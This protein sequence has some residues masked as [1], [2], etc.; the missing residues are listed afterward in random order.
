M[1]GLPSKAP[2]WIA[3]MVLAGTLVGS[4]V[5]QT[6]GSG[7]KANRASYQA[8]TQMSHEA[9]SIFTDVGKASKSLSNGNK[10]AAEQDIQAAMVVRN[11]LSMTAKA[12]NFPKVVPL[13]TEIEQSTDIGTIL[14]SKNNGKPLP[15]PRRKPVTVDDVNDQFTFVGVDLD[16]TKARLQSAKEAIQNNNIQAAKDTLNAVGEDLVVIK[17]GVD[18]PLLA[19]RENLGVAQ[20]AAKDKRPAEVTA[21]LQQSEAELKAYSQNSGSAHGHDAMVLQKSISSMLSTSAQN[22]LGAA[23]KIGGWWTEVNNWMQMPPA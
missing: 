20:L 15:S 21:A 6:P 2:G 13:Y 10:A 19:V 12:N 16:K 18:A 7:Q 22:A 11:R 14:A 4:A 17:V 9:A 8:L 23:A 3:G 5:A 1:R